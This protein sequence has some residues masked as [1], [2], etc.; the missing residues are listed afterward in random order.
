MNKGKI[1]MI[2]PKRKGR[3]A[4]FSEKDFKFTPAKGFIAKNIEAEN[5]RSIIFD[6]DNSEYCGC[7]DENWKYNKHY[8]HK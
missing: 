7:E 1:I 5:K 3:W 2:C 8:I 4:P 6:A